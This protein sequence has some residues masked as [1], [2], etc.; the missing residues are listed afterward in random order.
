MTGIRCSVHNLH[1]DSIDLRQAVEDSLGTLKDKFSCT[2]DYDVSEN[3]PRDVKLAVI[4]IVKE[5]VSNIAK[6]SSGNKV[7]V[8]L[9]EHPAFYQ[10]AVED[11]GRC[12]EIEESGIGLSNMQDRAASIGGIIRF[13]PSEKGFRVFMSA[14]KKGE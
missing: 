3:V 13:T 11:N 5:S 2:L 8:S 4:G 6:H 14:P 7:K 12:S 1:D 9:R 10:L